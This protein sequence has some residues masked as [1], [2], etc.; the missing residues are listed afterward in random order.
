[1]S[2]K[3]DVIFLTIGGNDLHFRDIVKYCLVHKTAVGNDCLNNLD[4]ATRRLQDGTIKSAVRKVLTDIHEGAKPWSKASP[5]ARI[6]LLGYPYLEGDPN[7]TI[8][9]RKEG[10]RSVAGTACGGREGQTNIVRVGYCLKQIED[11][12][13]TI[14]QDLINRLNARFETN[15]FLFVKTKALFAGTQPGFKGPNHE[16]FATKVNPNRWFIQPFV[17]AQSGVQ[18]TIEALGAGDELFTMSLNSVTYC[19]YNRWLDGRGRS[20]SLS[21][22]ESQSTELR[23]RSL[24]CRVFIN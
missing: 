20:Y 4:R 7:Y 16:L 11:L 6:V 5:T 24:Q 22:I 1:V 19:E 23:N 13:D 9:D 21:D 14:Q 8:V 18:G 17:D 3:Y 2:S 15:A 10:K 12:G